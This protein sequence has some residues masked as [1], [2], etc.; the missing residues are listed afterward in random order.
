MSGYGGNKGLN[1]VK[2]LRINSANRVDPLNTTDS[3]FTVNIIQNNLQQVTKIS[4]ISIQFPK[5]FYNVFQTKQKFNNAFA[6]YTEDSK[7]GPIQTTI[8]LTPGYYSYSDLTAAITAAVQAVNANVTLTWAYNSVTQRVSVGVTAGGTVTLVQILPLFAPYSTYGLPLTKDFDPF[9]LLGIDISSASLLWHVPSATV[10]TGIWAP[11][12]NN[13]SIAYVKSSAL[14]P[15]NS[16][17]ET[18]QMSDVIAQIDLGSVAQG[19]MA[20]WE[21]KQDVLCEID[22]GR[23]RMLSMIDIQ[24]VDHDNDPL[25]LQGGTLNLFFR[26]WMNT[27]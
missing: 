17:D 4:P 16:L 7:L 24:L 10:Y 20:T 3:N 23:P 8:L 5:N 18:G 25:D 15:Q 14:A 11:S 26:I 22:Y 6:L 27:Y 21:C 12:L 1:F 2:T 9:G 13:P 19:Q